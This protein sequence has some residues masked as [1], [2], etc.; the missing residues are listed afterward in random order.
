MIIDYCKWRPGGRWGGRRSELPSDWKG[1]AVFPSF[2]DG[3]LLTALGQHSPFPLPGRGFGS[4]LLHNF[5][6]AR[7]ATFGFS[8]LRL[9]CKS[10]ISHKHS[11]LVRFF[12]SIISNLFILWARRRGR[13]LLRQFYDAQDTVA[14]TLKN[15]IFFSRA[16]A[17]SQD[18]SSLLLLQ[19]PK[20]KLKQPSQWLPRQ[21]R[22][23][24][25][26]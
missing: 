3:I 10:C 12:S 24:L 14:S 7:V 26:I 15:F 18:T 16:Y 6:V 4:E 11:T 25:I 8:F 9:I 17:S 20:S 5:E 22:Q 21:S 1:V 13:R 19:P 23:Y 2:A